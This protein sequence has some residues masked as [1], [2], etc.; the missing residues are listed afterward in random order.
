MKKSVCIY[1]CICLCC[2]TVLLAQEAETNNFGFGEN[3]SSDD[4]FSIGIGGKLSVGGAFFFNDFKTLKDTRVSSLIDGKLHIHAT[5]P[6]T[7]AYFG[8]RVNDRTIGS[9]LGRKHAVFPQ[10]PQ[11]PRWIDEAFLKIFIGPAVISG[12]IQKIYW[13]RAE[14]FSVL[15]IINPCDTADLTLSDPQEP[16]IARPLLSTALY[17]PYDIKIEGIFLPVFEGNTIVT[18]KNNR[19]YSHKTDRV[20]GLDARVFERPVDTG[21]L[22][23]AQGGGRF[24][25]SVAGLHDFA[26]QYFYGRL[27]ETAFKAVVSDNGTVLTRLEP[28][29]NP[30]HHIGIDY[31]TG[32]G[33]LGYYAEFAANITSDRFGVLPFIQNSFIEWNT[34]ITYAAPHG[35][36]LDMS[37]SEK[38]ILN[39]KR[40]GTQKYDTEQ[41]LKQTDTVIAASLSQSLLRNSFEW[42]IGVEVG[43]EDADFCITPG[44]HWQFA[45]L[46]LDCN[47]GIFGGRKTGKRGQFYRNSFIRLTA[48][49]EF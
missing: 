3:E 37:A 15:D 10:Q 21:M 28:V 26:F 47:I 20:L 19:W 8:V 30:Y 48:A 6:M 16:K 23:Y 44:I 4:S 18:E 14:K 32:I 45:T 17:L 11:I 46:L 36:R 1:L 41:G 2:A 25:V 12:G 49:Y 22:Q 27:R 39:H 42:K 31:G 35:F 9:L 33:P 40:I 29:Y 13:G 43:L 7:E 24:S 38:I 5:A 34:G